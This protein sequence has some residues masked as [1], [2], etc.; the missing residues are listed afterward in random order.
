MAPAE[1]VR[2]AVVYCPSPGVC[3]LSDVEVAEG[4]TVEQ[5][6]VTSGLLERHGLVLGEV[7]LG[8]WSKAVDGS[9]VL[10]ERDRIE[11]YRELTVDPKE[12]RR[13]RYRGKR[14]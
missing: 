2:V 11:V 7:R 3:D 13:L 14:R 6:L 8:V 1:A 4:C 12:A 10:R 5:A 9:Q